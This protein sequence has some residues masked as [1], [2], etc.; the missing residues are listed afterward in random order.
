MHSPACA[1]KLTSTYSKNFNEYW[2]YHTQLQI[3][4]NPQNL[5]RI[6]LSEKPCWNY[7][8]IVVLRRNDTT[9]S[10]CWQWRIGV[11]WSRDAGGNNSSMQC[12]TLGNIGQLHSPPALQRYP[13]FC[14]H[15][16]YICTGN[17]LQLIEFFLTLH[18]FPGKGNLCSFY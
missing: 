5:I 17:S 1:N 7:A 4:A 3:Q 12:P 6:Q 9:I 15:S 18:L 16:L 11:V 14:L 10:R 8:G 2:H 13:L